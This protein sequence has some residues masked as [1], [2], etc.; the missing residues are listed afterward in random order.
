MHVFSR[1]CFSLL[2]GVFPFATVAGSDGSAVGGVDTVGVVCH[3]RLNSDNVPDVSSL[4]A[5]KR[6]FIKPDMTDQEKAIAAWRT[7]AMFQHQDVPPLE[8]LHNEL[9]VQDPIKIFNVYGYSFC[10]VASCD[11][12]ALAP[13]RGF[14]GTRLGDQPTQRA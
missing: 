11:V 3:I 9:G 8:F 1:L 13:L 7:T 6:A 12:A 5:W 10:S 14:K 2:L 4:E